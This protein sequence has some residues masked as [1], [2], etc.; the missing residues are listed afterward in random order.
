MTNAVA[1]AYTACWAAACAGA[2]AYAIMQRRRYGPGLRDYARFLVEP[3]KL[4]S[5]GL[6]TGFFVLIAPHSG[7]PTWDYV[8]AGF[9]S[10]FTYL[11]A[12]CA[13][14]ALYRAARGALGLGDACVAACAWMFSAS[15]SYDV[16]I[17]VR[18]GT[19]PPTWWSN[20]V[21]SSVLYVAAGLFWSLAHVEGR[22]VTFAFLEPEWFRARRAGLS[23]RVLAVGS[24]FMLLVAAM[25]APFALAAFE[26]LRR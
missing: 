2:V 18:D 14:G 21:A 7:D 13:V 5:F 17:F 3:W 12:P 23:Y 8:D 26:E 10:L 24:L 11:S 16:Y 22:G 20:I 1:V 25:M 4:A 15:W 6:A 9:M 19:Y